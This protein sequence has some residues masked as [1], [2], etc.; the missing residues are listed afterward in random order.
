MLSTKDAGC[1]PGLKVR[2]DKKQ[3]RE[4]GEAWLLMV[5]LFKSGTFGKGL[6]IRM[7]SESWYGLVLVDRRNNKRTVEFVN[8]VESWDC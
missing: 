7:R 1:G 8:A 6:G 5:G 4:P 3:H 2:Y